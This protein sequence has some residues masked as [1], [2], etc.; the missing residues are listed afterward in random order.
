MNAL[1]LDYFK[2][3]AVDQIETTIEDDESEQKD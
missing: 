1:G 2:I 3:D